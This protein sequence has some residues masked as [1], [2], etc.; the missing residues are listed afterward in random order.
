MKNT[1]N[2]TENEIKEKLI[3]ELI[4]DGEL[5]LYNIEKEISESYE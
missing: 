1:P 4:E 3:L 5:D 2:A